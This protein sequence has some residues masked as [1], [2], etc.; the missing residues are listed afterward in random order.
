MQPVNGAKW[1]EEKDEVGVVGVEE[2]G[3]DSTVDN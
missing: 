1:P 2:A 3:G